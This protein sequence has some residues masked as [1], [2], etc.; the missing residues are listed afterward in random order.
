MLQHPVYTWFG[1]SKLVVNSVNVVDNVA[2]AKLLLR[3][4][5]WLLDPGSMATE[6]FVSLD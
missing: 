4:R 5:R 1:L 2:C 3:H 6:H